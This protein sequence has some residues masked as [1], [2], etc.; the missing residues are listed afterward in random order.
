[1]FQLGPTNRVPQRCEPRLAALSLD[2]ASTQPPVFVPAL[3]PPYAMPP[4]RLHAFLPISNLTRH[5]SSRPVFYQLSHYASSIVAPVTEALP[6]RWLSDL[7]RRIGKCIIFGL[8]Q[9]QVDEAGDILRVVAREW[10]ELVAGSEG[11][12]TGRGRAGAEG[13]EVVWGDMVSCSIYGNVSR[14]E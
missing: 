10:R 4:P 12:L 6:A 11:F 8:K 9:E 5:I 2:C 7:K 3:Q 1:M 14:Q 13:R